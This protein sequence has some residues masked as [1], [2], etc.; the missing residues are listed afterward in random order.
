L[1]DQLVQLALWDTRR[2]APLK[3]DDS[4]ANVR[5]RLTLAVVLHG[6]KTCPLVHRHVA[7]NLAALAIQLDDP[8]GRSGGLIQRLHSRP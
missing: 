4:I 8:A 7:Q 6:V 5:H 2:R 1:I 3:P